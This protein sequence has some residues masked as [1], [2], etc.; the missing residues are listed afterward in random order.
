MKHIHKFLQI[1]KSTAVIVLNVIVLAVFLHCC[2]WGFFAFKDAFFKPSGAQQQNYVSRKYGGKIKD[3]YPQFSEEEINK[4]LHESWHRP[5]VYEPFTQFSE[6]ALKGT[7]VNVHPEGFRYSKNQGPWPPDE[8]YY[9]IFLFGGSTTFNYGLPDSLTIASHLQDILSRASSGKAVR[10][11]NFGR[12]YYYS[13]Q[14][15]VLFL[16]LI[17]R[18]YVPDMA[19][20]IDGYNEF[21][22]YHD[23]PYF[24]EKITRFFESRGTL[25]LREALQ[26]PL[27]RWPVVRAINDLKKK[28][29]SPSLAHEEMEDLKYEKSVNDLKERITDI[30]IPQYL[31]NKKMIES[32]AHAYRITPVFVWQPISTYK[33]DPQYYL[34][35]IPILDDV[36]LK[37]GYVRMADYMENHPV[38][39]NFFWCADIQEGVE[40]SLYVD[41]CHYNEKNS[42]NLARC[43]ARKMKAAGL[44]EPGQP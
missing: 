14:E 10:I 43:I 29:Q 25:S 39:E 7:Y 22:S 41:L 1:Y 6:R 13:S 5:F 9:N 40:E 23:R 21:I 19:I 8:K 42:R 37:Y 15:A 34:F 12:G 35:A 32:I 28:P 2:L 16:R 18:G 20:F 38:G 17:V 44:F 24:T 36:L 33:Y 4:I 30:V 27:S 26:G 31:A 3:G 11:Y